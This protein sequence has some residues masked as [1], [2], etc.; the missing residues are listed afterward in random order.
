MNFIDLQSQ[1]KLIKEQIDSSII[2]I[3]EK[4]SYIMGAEV[5][6]LESKLANYAGTTYA[7]TCS[8]GTD[9]LLMPLMAWGIGKCDA[10]FTSPFTFMATAEVVQFLGATTVFVD[11]DSD[12]YNIDPSKLDQ[13]IEKVKNEG[14]LTPKVI[15]P[16][17][18][19]GLAANYP[20]IEKVAQ[21]HNLLVLEDAA[22]SFGAS[23]ENKRAGS[24]GDCAATS[25]YPAKPLGCYGDG[26]AVFTD[27]EELFRIMHS[28]RVHGQG[29]DKYNNE[30]IGINGRLDTIQAAVLL[31]K[32]TLFDDEVMKRNNVARRYSNNLSNYIKT[33][34]I[35][36]NYTSVWAQYSL[37]AKDDAQRVKIMSFLKESNIPSVIYYPKPLHLQTAYDNLKYKIGDMPNSESV[38]DRIFSLPMHPYLTNDEID[39]IS[40]K[41]IEAILL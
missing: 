30:R 14:L 10:V 15:I 18:L 28:I 36:E 24:F 1:Y 5:Q 33:P 23:I 6:E 13:A 8:S 25:F 16:V 37:L 35:P 11:I 19:F 26:G 38:A 12:T 22:Q 41:V 29:I 20:E 27:N 21:K 32:M 3:L 40:E 17:D 34:T 39:F 2:N 31:A 7:L 4:G 9:A